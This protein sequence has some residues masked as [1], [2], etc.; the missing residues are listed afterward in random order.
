MVNNLCENSLISGYGKQIRQITPEII[1]EVAKELRIDRALPE[2][3]SSEAIDA[4]SQTSEI[5]DSP[6]NLARE[7]DSKLASLEAGQETR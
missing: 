1:R 2:E 4:Y 7:I 5:S 6:A 3:F